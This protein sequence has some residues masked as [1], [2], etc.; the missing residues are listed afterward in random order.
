M[1]RIPRCGCLTSYKAGEKDTYCI[2]SGLYYY[3]LCHQ[4]QQ[5][6]PWKAWPAIT[7]KHRSPSACLQRYDNRFCSIMIT[8]LFDWHTFAV[9]F[10]FF[11]T[12]CFARHFQFV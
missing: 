6:S 1:V 4:K 10:Y 8:D 7:R 2:M 3:S 5:A 12:R 9:F 11:Q